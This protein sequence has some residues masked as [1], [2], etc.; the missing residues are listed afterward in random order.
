[1]T[2]ISGFIVTLIMMTSF[3]AEAHKLI[4]VGVSPVMSTAGI[5]IAQKKGYFKDAGL[6]VELLT[7]DSSGAAM[8]VLLG[9]DELQVGAGN[10]SA[11]LITAISEGTGIK[12]VADKGHTPNGDGY[13]ALIVRTDHIKSGRYKSLKDLKGFKVGFTSL[14]G[15]SQQI[16][17]EKFLKKSNLSAADVEYIKLSYTE[18]NVALEK[19][20]I[21]ACIQLEPYISQAEN[22]GFA[23]KVAAAS[24]VYPEQQSAAL[25]YSSQFAKQKKEAI[26]FMTAYLKGVRDYNNAFIEKGSKDREVLITLLDAYF[27]LEPFDLWKKNKPV[28]LSSNGY[29]NVESLKNDL[30]WYQEKNYVKKIPSIEQ[31]VDHT[32]VEESLHSIGKIK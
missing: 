32:F 27:K 12:L 5:F 26:A 25:F 23:K 2:F 10:I 1:M 20:E 3:F 29:L 17:F 8:T 30:A 22:R 11:G 18:M 16:L 24:E 21:D 15:V 19:K 14:G 4:K 13:M 9:K 7:F 28:G 31:I 6:D